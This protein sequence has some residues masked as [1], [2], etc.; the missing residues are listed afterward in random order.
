MSIYNAYAPIYDAI[1]QGAF[2]EGLTAHILRSLPAPPRRALDLACGTGAAA[3]ALAASGARVVGVDR[4]QAMLRIARARARD[5]GL[6]VRWVAADMRRLGQ[7]PTAHGV[8]RPASFDL[9]T[10]LYDSLNYLTGPDDLAAA[11]AGAARLLRPGGR[12]VFDL[13]TAHEFKGWEDSDQVVFDSSDMLVYNRLSYD[14]ERKIAGGRIVWFV[15]E[16]DRWWRDEETHME[17][18][19]GDGEVVAALGAAG[20]RVAARRTPA[21]EPAPA[22]A[23]RVVYEAHAPDRV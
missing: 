23:P 16:S 10:C 4:S 11:C 7:R 12:F 22:D 15:R 19:W 21:W 14:A 18:A 13:N 17:R 1:G 6:P 8:L 9:I 3:L 20:L 2:A 5:R